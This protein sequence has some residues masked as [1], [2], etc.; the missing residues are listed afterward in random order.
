MKTT[1][2]IIILL[3]PLEMYSQHLVQGVV[4]D[5][6]GIEIPGVMIV[7]N[8]TQNDTTTDF[9]GR[10]E[11]E[12]T[13]DTCT[14]EFSWIGYESQYIAITQD[15]TIEIALEIY[16][17]YNT[18][19][20]TF[21]ADY[22]LYNSVFGI[23]LSNGFDEEP[24]IHF[25]DFEDDI[26]FKAYASTDFNKSYS[27]SGVIGLSHTHIRYVV[28][29]SLGYSVLNFET[30]DL[31]HRDLF[32]STKI[33]YLKNTALLFKTGYQELQGKK[34]FGINLGFEQVARNIYFGYYSGYY[35]DYFI[36][37]IYFQFCIPG[38]SLLSFRTVY[39]R[40]DKFNILNF[41]INY[42]FVRNNNR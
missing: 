4:K 12:T 23:Q 7:E 13:H 11:I 30:K 8:G 2:I 39:N 19:W 36:H 20:L 38:N 28:R 5:I 15:T 32:I 42:S 29:F 26:V 34:N 17:P 6:D 25:E 31:F 9:S 40:L 35:F 37:S 3:I 14:I 16:N 24:L 22:E 21:G 1:L 41:G 10:F 33:G 18:R 27:Y